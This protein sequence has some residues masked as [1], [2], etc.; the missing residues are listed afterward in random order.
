MNIPTLET[1]RLLL[2]PPC[3]QAEDVYRRFYTDADASRAYSGP[4]SAGAA[5]SRL[6]SDLGSWHLQGF[7]VWLIQRK[8]EGDFVGTCGFWQGKA[9]PRELTWWLLPEFRG[10]GIANEASIAAIAHAYRVFK[11]EA[12]ETYMSDQNQLAQ[13]LVQRL[14]GQKVGRQTFPDGLERD[15]YRI[16]DSD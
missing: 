11:W 4:L 9:W 10:A 1:D 3:E 8:A 13:A 7:G 2:L 16:P 6:A 12:V 14:G 5:W 15:L